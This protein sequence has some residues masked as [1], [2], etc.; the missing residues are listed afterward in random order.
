MKKA[1]TFNSVLQQVNIIKMFIIKTDVSK[2]AIN[3][4]L[5]QKDS[6]EK[7]YLVVYNKWKLIT[8]KLNYLIHEKELLIIKQTL[9]QWN[10][11]I[12]NEHITMILTDHESLKYL[13]TTKTP[14]KHLA[15]WVSEFV[16]YDLNIKYHKDSETVVLNMLSCRPDFISKMPVNWVKKMWSVFLWHLN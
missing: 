13:K 16:K 8:A 6:D 7:L 14:L 2:W 3:Y 15:H 9:H 5:L 12:N 10:Y 11:Y 1:L 4:S